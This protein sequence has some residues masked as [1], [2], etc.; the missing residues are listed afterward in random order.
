VFRNVFQT[1][2][3][4]SANRSPNHASVPTRDSFSR[5]AKGCASSTQRPEKFI[6]SSSM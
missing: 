1:G 4:I 5:Q 2:A 3:V 6:A